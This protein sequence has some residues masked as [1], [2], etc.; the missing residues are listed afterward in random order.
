MPETQLSSTLT[1]SPGQGFRVPSFAICNLLCWAICGYG[2][3]EISFEP[4][5]IL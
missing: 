4:F 1:A 5:I 2:K 3:V